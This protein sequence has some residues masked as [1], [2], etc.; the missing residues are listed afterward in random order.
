MFQLMLN[1]VPTQNSDTQNS[2]IFQNSDTFFALT[3]MSLFW[4]Q[5]DF[6]KKNTLIFFKH[7][8]IKNSFFIFEKLC[9]A[10]GCFIKCIFQKPRARMS[11]KLS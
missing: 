10:V 6:G 11:Q 9:Y 3:K 2:D 5:E 1:T 8:A 7:W 4:Q